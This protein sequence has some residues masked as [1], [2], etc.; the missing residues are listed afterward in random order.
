MK[1]LKLLTAVWVLALLA[2]CNQTRNTTPG[3]PKVE[4]VKTQIE[5]PESDQT[6]AETPRKHMDLV[7]AIDVSGSMEHIIAATQ[8]KVWAI[9]NEMLKSRPM[10]T[11][12]V[13]LIA[14][15]GESE[16][17][18][19]G[20]GFKV[21]DLTEDLDQAY[22]NLMALRTDGGSTECVGRA[23]YEASHSISW[24]KTDET[25]KV[26]FVLGNEPANQDRNKEKYGYQVTASAAIRN[27][28][29]IN[30]V[31]CSS[32]EPATPEW[33]EISRLAD[34]SF[35]TVGLEGRIAAVSTPMDKELADLQRK[36]IGTNVAYGGQAGLKMVSELNKAESAAACAPQSVQADRSI[37]LANQKSGRIGTWDLL[38]A[39]NEKRVK[40]EELKDEELPEEMRKITPEK[41]RE[42]LETKQKDRAEIVK[43]IQDLSRARDEY[44]QT[45]IKKQNLDKNTVDQII[46]NTLRQQAE[47]KGFKFQ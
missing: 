47:K 40:L 29:Q 6:Q 25:L 42:Y 32:H 45:E 17:C 2:G 27:G 34:G 10:P 31:Y 12:R 46:L 1:T 13:G 7:F 33:A 8:Q 39:V 15:R 21:W 30:T 20:T 5:T 26:L 9:V 16:E 22:G 3:T 28:I 19:G 36:L 37:A 4:S 24:Q 41:R 11:L 35:L 38:D 18:Y 44:I 23:I 43:K 14:Y